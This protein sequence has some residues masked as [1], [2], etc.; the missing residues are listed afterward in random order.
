MTGVVRIQT[1]VSFATKQFRA[2]G[3]EF[4]GVVFYSWFHG[5]S[6]NMKHLWLDKWYTESAI[7]TFTRGRIVLMVLE[8][9]MFGTDIPGY[10]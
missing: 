4:V 6:Q 2:Q 8:W 3:V 1:L 5:R 9:S 10:S 7:R